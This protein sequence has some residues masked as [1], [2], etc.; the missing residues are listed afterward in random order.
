MVTQTLP[1]LL[2]ERLALKPL[3][4][5]SLD[6]W[7]RQDRPAL[8]RALGIVFPDVE[9]DPPMVG[10]DLLEI[11]ASMRPDR[12]DDWWIWI[13]AV[14]DLGVAVGTLAVDCTAERD[15]SIRIAHWTYPQWKERAFAR[16]AA[17]AIAS[18]LLER[19]RDGAAHLPIAFRPS[20]PLGHPVQSG[21]KGHPG[22]GESLVYGSPPRGR[23]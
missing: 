2:S 7:L 20:G 22:I 13:S 17:D 12:T 23:G 3:A 9:G 4:D 6:A 10:A 18:W 19:P 14:R 1:S 15:G 16:E 11:R 5:G 8:E 21:S